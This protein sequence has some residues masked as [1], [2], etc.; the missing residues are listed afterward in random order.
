MLSL[1][2]SNFRRVGLHNR[3]FRIESIEKMI[4]HGNR[5]QTISGLLLI[6]FGCLGGRCSD[7]LGFENKL[8]N[9]TISHEIQNLKPWICGCRSMGIWAL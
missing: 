3:C 8:E 6:L 2:E 1:S 9:R 4:F 7:F 5:F